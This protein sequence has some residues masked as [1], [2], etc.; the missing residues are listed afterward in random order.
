MTAVRCP[1]GFSQQRAQGVC[2]LGQERFNGLSSSLPSGLQPQSHQKT[3][4]NH[5]A[6]M[7][8]LKHLNALWG[9]HQGNDSH[10]MDKKQK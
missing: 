3:N 2:V 4:M 5:L 6:P 7:W 10:F 1:A 8:L 9:G